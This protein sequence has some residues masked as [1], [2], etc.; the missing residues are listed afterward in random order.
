[1]ASTGAVFLNG[2]LNASGAR[3]LSSTS[4][5]SLR[6]AVVAPAKSAYR[7]LRAAPSVGL[8]P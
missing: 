5:S 4:G 1:M 3:P 7:R 2:F 6:D 8:A